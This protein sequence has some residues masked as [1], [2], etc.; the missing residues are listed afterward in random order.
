MP[1]DHTSELIDVD[2]DGHLDLLVAGDEG[3][4]PSSHILGGRGTGLR[5][6]HGEHTAER[7]TDF[8]IIV[9]IDIGDIDGDGINDLL[10]NRVGTPP[11]RSWYDGMYLQLLKGQEDRRTFSDVSESSIDKRKHCSTPTARMG[12]G[13]CG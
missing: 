1:E 5:Q 9:D 2:R 7:S 6:Q 12:V 10:L 4:S 3:N 13:S 8:G 11:G